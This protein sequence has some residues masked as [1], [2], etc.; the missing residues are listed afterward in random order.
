MHSSICMYIP[1]IPPMVSPVF[2]LPRV[3]SAY[4][5]MF[6]VEVSHLRQLLSQRRGALT[7]ARSSLG[8]VASCVAAAAIT[9]TEVDC[10]CACLPAESED[11]SDLL[12]VCCRVVYFAELS[13]SIKCQ[14]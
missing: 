9:L 14:T 8:P 6:V 3:P 12:L 11:Y 10:T 5:C 2:C 7:L 1:W 13:R 4:T